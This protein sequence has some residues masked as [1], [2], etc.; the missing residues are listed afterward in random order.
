MEWP[1]EFDWGQKSEKQKVQ[2][3]RGNS[4]ENEM[5]SGGVRMDDE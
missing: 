2:E 3:E 1:K 5:K 4:Q